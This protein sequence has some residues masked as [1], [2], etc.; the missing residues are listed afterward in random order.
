MLYFRRKVIAI[1][2]E[3]TYGTDPVPTVAA[4]AVLVRNFK[5]TPL[6]QNY[7][8]RDNALNYVGHQGLIVVDQKVRFSFD[9]ELSGSGVA[10]TAPAYA[11]LLKACGMSETLVA[12]TS[13]T[14]APVAPGAEVSVTCYF[15]VGGRRHKVVGC[16][17]DVEIEF[18]RGKVPFYKFSF[19]GLYVLPDDSALAA[20]TLTGYIKPVAVNNANT[21]PVSIA[22]Y[23][24]KLQELRLK[25]GNEIVYRNL[26][27]SEA[28]RLVD[29][30]STGS[31]KF[32]S[33]LLAT[34]DFFTLVKNGTLGAISI[35]HGPATNQVVVAGS[36]VQLTNPSVDEEDK[37]GMDSLDLAWVPSSASN[38]EWSIVVK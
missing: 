7:D 33:E 27:N 32:E 14:Y 36:N 24:A 6:D 2:S 22:G 19:T 25:V 31:V 17:G 8:K 38:D 18:V 3:A 35:T 29:R 28:V 9:V 16:I 23:A 1:K 26:P 15:W 13:A 12:L 11:P 20:P 5:I 37:I 34:K 10:G 21:T 4:N 30:E